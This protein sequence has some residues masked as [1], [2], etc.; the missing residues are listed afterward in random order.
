[1]AD[2]AMNDAAPPTSTASKK[3]ADLVKLEAEVQTHLQ[4]AA[5][6]RTC[7]ARQQT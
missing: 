7:Q 2:V 1:M 6:A 5:Q 3:G 4:A